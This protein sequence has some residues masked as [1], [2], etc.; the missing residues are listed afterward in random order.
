[1]LIVVASL[2]S[3]EFFLSVSALNLLV[4][5][6]AF[7]KLSLDLSLKLFAFSRLE[8]IIHQ[9]F[10]HQYLVVVE[11]VNRYLTEIFYEKFHVFPNSCKV[12]FER[13]IICTQFQ[14]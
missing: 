1:M 3:I 7:L 2:P 5:F 11:F 12:G 10:K 4:Q 13:N 14:N 6:V 9:V 8:F